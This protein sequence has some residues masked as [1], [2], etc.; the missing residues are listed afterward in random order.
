V[1]ACNCNCS[2]LPLPQQ[3]RSSICS[4]N[5]VTTSAAPFPSQFATPVI[6][7]PA[8]SLS[9][10]LAFTS[11]VI[12]CAIPVHICITRE[13]CM[14]AGRQAEYSAQSSVPKAGCRHGITSAQP[15]CLPPSPPLQ[16]ADAA[17][18][19]S[20]ISHQHQH[21]A[22]GKQFSQHAGQ[23]PQDCIEWVQCCA[24]CTHACWTP[25]TAFPLS[26]LL[27]LAMVLCR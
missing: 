14:Q 20:G 1:R 13:A 25:C 23:L 5:T 10:S 9:A 21:P 6:L 16:P 12:R 11:V 7:V 19:G 3:Y 15:L 22:G 17:A 18:G 27:Q 8:L 26:P 24:A 2:W 4:S